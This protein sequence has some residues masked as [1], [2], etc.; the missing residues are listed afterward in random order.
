LARTGNDNI[1]PLPALKLTG[2]KPVSLPSGDILVV[3]ASLPR[4]FYCHFSFPAAGQF[5]DY[6]DQQIRFIRELEP[7]FPD[8]LKVRTDA[9]RFGWDVVQR[10]KD[11][12][13][14]WTLDTIHADLRSRLN[15]CRICVGTYNATVFLETMAANFPTITFFDPA[16]FEV[17]PDA[18]PA[19]D[20]LRAVGLL[21]DSPE[22]AAHLLVRIGND[23]DSWWA[24]PELQRVRMTFCNRY[25]R[26]TSD[27]LTPWSS[28]LKKVLSE[29]KCKL[30]PA[31]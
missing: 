15:E 16:H 13:C 5:L 3:L 23:V 30:S 18:I 21:H 2:A 27:W 6:L 19:M 7:Y 8:V 17:R 10:I 24:D 22:S 4:Y 9:D 20:M 31:H 11:A 1:V 26:T 28:F 25:A 12:G 14:G 29:R